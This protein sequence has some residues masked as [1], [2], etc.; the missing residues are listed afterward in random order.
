MRVA[1]SHHCCVVCGH[2]PS[3]CRYL[4]GGVA[5]HRWANCKM[6]VPIPM[7]KCQCT[8][9][10]PRRLWCITTTAH[11]RIV[12]CL[13][14][15]QFP[16][17]KGKWEEEALRKGTRGLGRGGHRCTLVHPRYSVPPFLPICGAVPSSAP[18]PTQLPL[19]LYLPWFVRNLWTSA[20]RPGTVKTLLPAVIKSRLFR[21]FGTKAAVVTNFEGCWAWLAVGAEQGEPARAGELPSWLQIRSWP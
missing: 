9:A 21:D 6:P 14:Y 20:D 13:H 5:E 8:S 15:Q 2:V 10:L 18:I 17:S 1:F 19:P 7:P 3:T 4:H 11:G 16:P 12:I